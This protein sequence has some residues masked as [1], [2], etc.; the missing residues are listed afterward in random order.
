MIAWIYHY[1]PFFSM[2]RQLFLHHYLPAHIC[3]ALVTG[4]VFH[5]IASESINFP[6]SIAGPTTRRR[7]R[8]VAV[9][10][11]RM[12]LAVAVVILLQLAAFGFLS[13]L[14]YGTPGLEPEEVNRRRLLSSWT[15]VRFSFS[16]PLSTSFFSCSWGRFQ[17][18]TST[19]FFFTI[20]LCQV[21]I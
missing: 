7:P 3:S 8:T 6:I 11:K 21:E 17:V 12:I 1:L 2:S 4:S 18:L 10:S 15:L 5:F 13:P 19:I 14:T 9:V 20:A 16:F